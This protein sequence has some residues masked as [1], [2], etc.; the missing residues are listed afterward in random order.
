MGERVVFSGWA[1]GFYVFRS[2][3][4]NNEFK[5]KIYVLGDVRLLLMEQDCLLVG[6]NYLTSHVWGRRAGR[7]AKVRP[8]TVASILAFHSHPLGGDNGV[9]VNDLCSLDPHLYG[10]LAEG[11][12]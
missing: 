7:T 11:L 1:L 12:H 4:Q 8:E 9:R 3:V 6:V 10:F 5:R 2:S